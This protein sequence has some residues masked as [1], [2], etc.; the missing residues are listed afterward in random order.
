MPT[1]KNNY[2]FLK[3]ITTELK[4]KSNFFQLEFYQCPI[5]SLTGIFRVWNNRFYLGSTNKN[6][7]IY[8]LAGK[9]LGKL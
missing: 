3:S 5:S 9:T 2:I 1:F 6:T 4:R 7:S 8:E